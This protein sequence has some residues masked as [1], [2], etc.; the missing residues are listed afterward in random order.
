MRQAGPASPG[1]RGRHAHLPGTA[2]PAR[3]AP[4]TSTGARHRERDPLSRAPPPPARACGLV[5]RR[6]RVSALGGDP[7]HD[8]QPAGLLVPYARRH[9]ARRGRRERFYAGTRMTGERAP[10]GR[11]NALLLFCRTPTIARDNMASPFATLPWED[12][13]V[14]F[15][16]F[17]GDLLMT[18]RRIEATDI[19][20]YRNAEQLSD[21]YF[22]PFRAMVRLMDLDDRPFA[23]QVESALDHAFRANYTRVV[24]VIDNRP[25]LGAA[26]LRA[27]FNQL[28]YEDDCTVVM[29][30]RDGKC[31]LIGLKSNHS[32]LFDPGKADPVE[33][34][35]V[36]L[37]RL[38]ALETQLF[39]LPAE[40]PLDSASGL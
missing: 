38:C 29:P 16:A 37:Q 25:T 8:P 20:V 32:R 5:R 6:R 36:L 4:E 30:T 23:A 21:D 31:V 33:R 17:A 2:R 10:K 13:D 15:T 9:R 35:H 14:L 1:R 40:E 22:L 18:A 27:A 7:P 19:L 24:A 3:R 34:P 11:E 12:L 39:L 26:T 28:G